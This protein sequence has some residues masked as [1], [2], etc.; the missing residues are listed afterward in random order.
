MQPWALVKQ[1]GKV[2]VAHCTCMAG[3]GEA[4]SHIGA[5]LF[6]IQVA[7][8]HRDSLTC[9]DGENSWLPAYCKKLTCVPL[10]EVDFTSATT[11]K[12]RIDEGQAST[13]QVVRRPRPAP[14]R[15]SDE[16]WENFL[17]DALAANIQ[18]AFLS[19]VDGYA[20]AYVPT[21]AKC[22]SALLC[23]LFKDCAVPSWNEVLEECDNLASNIRVDPE[24][25]IV[26]A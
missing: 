21:A 7:V 3:L 22:K 2:V 11:K 4:C 24:V 9:T 25:R 1:D 19:L 15:P 20:D 5:I 18:P 14:V 6:Y 10:S 23:S 8:K 26:A 12:R 17:D 16:Q 13:T